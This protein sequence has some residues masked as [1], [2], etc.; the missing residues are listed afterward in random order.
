MGFDLDDAAGVDLDFAGTELDG[1]HVRMRATSIGGLLE[2]AAVAE[3]IE[4]LQAG[5]SP[6]ALR[7]RLRLVLAPL[8]AVLVSWDLT[9]GGEPVPA[10]LDGLLRL[11]PAMLGRVI[12]AYVAAQA[13]PDD[14][15]GKNSPSGA[16]SPEEA[17]MLS[18]LA[19][20]SVPLANSPAPS[21]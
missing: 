20:M 3:D 4:G 6:G 11:P 17:A 8:G 15:L 5:E 18:D 10:D 12:N 2:I 21:S 14:D 1:L 13:Q 7:E 16:R 9:A 19:D